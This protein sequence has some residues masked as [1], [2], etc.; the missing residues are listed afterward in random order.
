M[1]QYH[2][3]IPQE[4]LRIVAC[5]PGPLSNTSD[6]VFQL[7]QFVALYVQ[8]DIKN[9]QFDCQNDVKQ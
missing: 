7:A 2:R 4:K 8:F 3:E 9:N 6:A 1:L 5:E